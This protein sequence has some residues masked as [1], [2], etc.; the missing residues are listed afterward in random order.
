MNSDSNRKLEL[1]DDQGSK[2]PFPLP[3]ESLDESLDLSPET[4]RW[5]ARDAKSAVAF[6]LP[7]E[8]VP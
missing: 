2:Q 4:A 1:L 3:V 8:G 7:G 5:H 6:A